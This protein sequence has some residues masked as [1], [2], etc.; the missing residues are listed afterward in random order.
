MSRRLP[1][2]LNTAA[3][4][5]R[6][7]VRRFCTS[8]VLARLLGAAATEA[9]AVMA[10]TAAAAARE[11]ASI[12]CVL[13]FTVISLEAHARCDGPGFELHLTVLRGQP[14]LY[15]GASC[16]IADGGRLA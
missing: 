12:L 5:G 8:I 11:R 7:V 14:E 3:S 1:R 4:L 16:L 10:A 9:T 15:L 6:S 2:S 13:L